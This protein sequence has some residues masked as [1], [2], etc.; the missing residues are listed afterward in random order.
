[1]T[2]GKRLALALK[3]GTPGRAAPDGP[4]AA[5]GAG[6]A[7]TAGA[8]VKVGGRHCAGRKTAPARAWCRW[9]GMREVSTV[10]MRYAP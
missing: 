9:G 3:A 1:M 2:T 8:L 10:G 7:W 4:G 6:V 5:P